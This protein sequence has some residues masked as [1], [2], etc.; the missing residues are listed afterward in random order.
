MVT[1]LPMKSEL[2]VRQLLTVSTFHTGIKWIMI[3]AIFQ[4]D[5]WSCMLLCTSKTAEKSFMCKKHF[6][7]LFLSHCEL[8]LWTW[9]C[10]TANG[11]IHGS[12][13]N[14]LILKGHFTLPSI[15]PHH[16]PGNISRWLVNEIWH[17]KCIHHKILSS[18]ILYISY[19]DE[20]LLIWMHNFASSQ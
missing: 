14:A 2:R 19:T 6:E 18:D 10:A 11:R 16:L 8:T 20:C 9:H 15:P 1:W 17:E 5:W 7:I 12:G 4:Q 3:N 13:R